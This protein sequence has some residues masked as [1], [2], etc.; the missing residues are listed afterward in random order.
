MSR[1]CRLCVLVFSF[2]LLLLVFNGCG[3]WVG[4]S[5]CL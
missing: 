3:F 2:W 1:C 5:V 4:K